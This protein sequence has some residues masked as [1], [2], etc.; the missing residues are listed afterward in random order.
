VRAVIA[1]K[2]VVYLLAVDDMRPGR[3]AGV[4]AGL[5]GE[6]DEAEASRPSNKTCYLRTTTWRRHAMGPA[7][8]A[9]T[10]EDSYEGFNEA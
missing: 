1:Y 5:L 3:L 10:H 9:L 4:H 8:P 2:L 7:T 6:G